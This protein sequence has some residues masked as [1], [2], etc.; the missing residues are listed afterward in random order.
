MVQMMST[1]EAIH[2]QSP[3]RTRWDVFCLLPLLYV[4]LFVPFQ[5]GFDLKAESGVETFVDL[6][7]AFDILFNFFTG[8]DVDGNVELDKKKVS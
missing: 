5:I 3:L 6:V 2:P 1:N 7:F 4:C 8:Y